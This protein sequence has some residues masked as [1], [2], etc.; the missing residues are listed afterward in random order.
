MAVLWGGGWLYWVRS[1]KRTADDLDAIGTYQRSK[2]RQKRHRGKMP[3]EQTL[4]PEKM[5]PVAQTREGLAA[6]R[7][8]QPIRTPSPVELPK[9]LIYVHV[10]T[11]A[12][13]CLGAIYLVLDGQ[14]LKAETM[15]AT[16]GIS[17]VI[18]MLAGLAYYFVHRVKVAI[19]FRTDD[20]RAHPIWAQH[21]QPPPT[22]TQPTS[23]RNPPTGA[24]PPLRRSL[25]G[26]MRRR[27]QSVLEFLIAGMA[28]ALAISLPLGG[29]AGKLTPRDHP[30]LLPFEVYLG[31]IVGALLLA[32]IYWYLVVRRCSAYEPMTNRSASPRP[33][34]AAAAAV[35]PRS[36]LGTVAPP[37][38]TTSPVSE[39]PT[40]DTGADTDT[41][42]AA[43]ASFPQ[44]RRIAGRLRRRE[45][46]LL[47]FLIAGTAVA[48]AI[49]LPLG[50]GAKGHLSLPM[51]IYLLIFAGTLGLTVLYYFVCRR[52]ADE[53]EARI[54]ALTAPAPDAPP[55]PP[56]NE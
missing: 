55:T 42:E 26:R 37:A 38:S 14:A 43:S 36:G 21:E 48:L 23:P 25:A 9:I 20:F 50:G 35:R 4:P 5:A 41:G 11:F 40:P 46:S 56:H 1:V 45:L 6:N 3:I 24:T 15:V 13:M 22:T 51:E 19:P 33:V 54:D 49:S 12:T 16:A 52:Q 18:Y 44:R 2:G 39:A 7:Q 30:L 17:F 31:I 53:R 8:F 27:D 29:G 28:L 32:L 47:E 34:A 10:A